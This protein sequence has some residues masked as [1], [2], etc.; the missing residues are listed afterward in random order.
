MGTHLEFQDSSFSLKKLALFF[1]FF[2]FFSFLNFICYGMKTI[3]IL[4][5]AA[6][7]VTLA[8]S[9]FGGECAI[10]GGVASHCTSIE[11]AREFKLAYDLEHWIMGP[12][13]KRK[14]MKRMKSAPKSFK[15]LL[16]RNN[17]IRRIAQD[18]QRKTEE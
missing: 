18:F 16:Q 6:L 9:T 13:L 4:M 2:S 11:T 12:G 3:G 10:A 5:V 15:E 14:L 7:L 1:V 8:K 17:L